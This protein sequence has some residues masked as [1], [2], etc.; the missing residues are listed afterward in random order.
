MIYLL[1]VALSWNQKRVGYIIIL[2]LSVF[3]LVFSVIVGHT[4]GLTPNHV[5][6]IARTTGTF[7]VWVVLLWGLTLLSS[8]LL[9]IYGLMKGKK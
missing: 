6:Q 2:V 5:I 8:L 1:G 3:G 7:F 4:S 9:S